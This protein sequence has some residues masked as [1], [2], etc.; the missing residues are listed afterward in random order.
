LTGAAWNYAGAAVLILTQVVST[1][2]TARLVSPEEFG[3][4]ATAQAAQGI[5]GYF[6]LP[7]IGQGLLRR[8]HLGPG[9]AGT[10]M[11]VSLATSALVATAMWFASG[12]WSDAWHVPSAAAPVRVLALALALTGFSVVPLALLR[13]GLRFRAAA[14]AETLTQVAGATAGVVLALQMHSATALAIG[15]AVTAGALLA[16]AC[17]LTRT[18]L[19]LDFVVTEAREL[20]SFAS[21][22]GVQSVGFYMLYT[23][24]SWFIARSFGATK[25]GLYSRANLIVGLPVHYL[26]TG[27][28]KVMYP[29]YGRIGAEMR[30]TRT[31][32]TEAITMATGITWPFLALVAGSSPLVVEI[33]LGPTWQASA[34]LVRLCAL[35]GCAT[36]P[37]VMLAN[38]AE[39]F[40]WMRLVWAMQAAYGLVLAGAIT[41]VQFAT[42]SIE[43]LLLGVA[44]AQWTG[45]VL[46]LAAYVRRGFL[47]K[48]IVI[49][50]HAIHG[51][52]ALAIFAVAAVCEDASR[53]Q[54]LL[55][56]ITI[57]LAVTLFA[58][59]ILL[60][61]RH[62]IPAVEI[63]GTR[64]ALVAG[65]KRSQLLGWLGFRAA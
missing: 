33:L 20:V 64:L 18:E 59:G 49:A 29:Y 3:A 17:W 26:T 52:V 41:L 43:D 65:G 54:P 28:V 30:R 44:A 62:R 55:A 35:V 60:A 25:L 48:Q 19:R 16:A 23:T 6:T 56:R 46:L 38:S 40:G 50:G 39:A 7:A 27:L 12:V 9:A 1:A 15:Q 14:T 31:F 53:G 8:S 5:L 13:R 32:L 4:Y 47:E 2:A 58:G 63:L 24:P 51:T 21:Q 10:A 37:W 22:V 34:D 61:G 45:Y 57:A 11:V 36:L 42:L